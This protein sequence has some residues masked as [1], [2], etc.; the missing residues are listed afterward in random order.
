[1]HNDPSC[2]T[3]NYLVSPS[4]NITTA[5]AQLT[6]RNA[7]NLEAGFDGG[8]LEVTTDAGATWA[9]ITSAGIGG[10]FVSGGYNRTISVN[11]SSPIAGRQAW[12]A[13]S[14]GTAATPTYITTVANLGANLA[15]K[16]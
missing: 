8:V 13:L 15:G 14:G 12:S 11:F 3:D 1:F 2:V 10:S 16:T 9:D 5:N 4:V 7:F 6:F